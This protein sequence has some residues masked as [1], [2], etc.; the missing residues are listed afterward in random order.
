MTKGATL[1]WSALLVCL[2]AAPARAQ[3]DPDA[4][5]QARAHFQTGTELFQAADYER[6]LGEY[7]QAYELSHEPAL[8]YNLYLCQERL[9]NLAEATDWLARYLE[10]ASDVHR[11]E[12]LTERLATMRRRLAELPPESAG[13]PHTEEPAPEPQLEPEEELGP[14]AAAAAEPTT[15]LPEPTVAEARGF[16]LPIGA[17]VSYGVGGLG[18]LGL[19][20]FGGLAV[21]EDSRIADM[22]PEGCD[23]SEIGTLQAYQIAADT[24]LALG[25]AGALAG[26]VWTIVALATF[27]PH[28]QVTAR[29]RR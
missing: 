27:D 6:A 9:G 13:A 7:T 8:M 12:V 4:Q 18:A 16:E 1:L 23:E 3:E 10:E 21:A 17:I 2:L 24:S 22:C 5:A 29:A 19:A 28:A 15:A 26:V 25:L 20:I 11:R 14:P